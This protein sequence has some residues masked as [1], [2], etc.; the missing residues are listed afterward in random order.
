MN[1][2]IVVGGLAAL[3]VLAVLVGLL[4]RSQEGAWRHIAAER[5]ALWEDRQELSEVA[6]TLVREAGICPCRGC[7]KIRR[8]FG[9]GGES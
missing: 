1:A 8:L 5:R 2:W 9:R 3:V 7:R 6:D 4:E